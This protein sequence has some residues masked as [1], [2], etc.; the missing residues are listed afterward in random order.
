MQLKIIEPHQRW[1][2]SRAMME[3]H[4][5]RK[6]IFV[7]RLGWDL[8]NKGSWLEVDEFDN[9]YCVYLLA[10]APDGSHRASLRLLPSNRPHMLGSVFRELCA[11]PPPV[12]EDVWEISRLV[13]RPEGSMGTSMLRAHRLLA[14]ALVEFALCNGIGRYS[15]VTESLRLPALLSV[16]WDVAPLGLPTMLGGEQLQALEIRIDADTLPAMRERFGIA[17][18]V[19]RLNGEGSC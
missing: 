19:L 7:D 17:E 10:R 8:P 11:A 15:L 12:G 13:S 1:Q 14:L 16:G 9:E 2:F 5:H 3:M 4:H 18:S 6:Q